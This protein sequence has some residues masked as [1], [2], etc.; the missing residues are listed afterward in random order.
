MSKIN[1]EF[2]IK[3]NDEVQISIDSDNNIFIK[4][5]RSSVGLKPETVDKIMAIYKGKRDMVKAL[6]VNN[7]DEV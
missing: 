1:G 7:E 5:N 4:Q 3:I 2:F 6:F